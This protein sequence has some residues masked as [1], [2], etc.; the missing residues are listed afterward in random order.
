MGEVVDKLTATQAIERAFA[1]FREFYGSVETDNVLLEGVELDREAWLI[2]IGFDFGRKRET[3]F[4]PQLFPDGFR[5]PVREKRRFH[6]R[7]S[8]GEFLKM[9]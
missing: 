4:G 7:A 3:R 5:E 2:T 8:D 9:D 6:L 1:V